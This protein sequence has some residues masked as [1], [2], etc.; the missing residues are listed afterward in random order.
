MKMLVVFLSLLS[1]SQHATG[2]QVYQGEEPVVLPCQVN[3]SNL[4]DS[5]VVW[6]RADLKLPVVHRFVYPGDDDLRDQN[7]RY[8]NR[9]SMRTD[10]LQT[11]D[12]SLSLRKPNI[13]DS[14]NYTCSVI[15]AK[16]KPIETEV[17]LQVKE[18]PPPV[19]PW[20]VL[21]LLL[22]VVAAVGGF[23]MCRK[24]KELKDKTIPQVEVESGAE[25]VQLPFITTADLP[26]DVRVEW[27]D[28][29]NRKVHVYQ[30]GSDQ[31]EEQDEFYRNRTE[32]KKD[33]LRTGDLSLTL[34]H[35]TGNVNKPK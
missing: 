12:L 27:K 30:D 19:W 34:K 9:T 2:E 17:K 5:I 20:I 33:L 16:E 25:S 7:Q 1:V 13:F 4:M 31:P 26:G 23:I 14:D 18:P 6:S 21:V 24:Y 10:A 8:R 32:M 35:P 29:N 15:K 28:W 11:G 3:A 22:V